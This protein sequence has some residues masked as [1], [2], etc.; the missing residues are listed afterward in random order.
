MTSY[1]FSQQRESSRLIQY[2]NETRLT[3]TKVEAIELVKVIDLLERRLDGA[4][5]REESWKSLYNNSRETV[6]TQY[7]TIEVLK[8]KIEL[9]ESVNDI[10]VEEIERLKKL[11]RKEKFNYF[12]YGVLVGGIVVIILI[13]V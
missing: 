9:L 10:D 5:E 1:C 4:L 2:N 3:L 12:V 13:L 7:N 8:F 11:L 6:T